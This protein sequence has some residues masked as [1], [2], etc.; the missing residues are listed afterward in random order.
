M[1]FIELVN[2]YQN[3]PVNCILLTTKYGEEM[4]FEAKVLL[5]KV[6]KHYNN[7]D[8]RS[9]AQYLAL[10]FR[11]YWGQTG[12]PKAAAK[13]AMDMGIIYHAVNG[14]GYPHADGTFHY[15]SA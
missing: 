4:A 9:V 3:H 7:N 10:F 15:F 12:V 8:A 5:H 14:V 1:T 13:I 11:E 6:E 2:N